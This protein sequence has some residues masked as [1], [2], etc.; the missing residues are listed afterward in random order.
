MDPRILKEIIN[1]WESEGYNW[2][3]LNDEVSPKEICEEYKIQDLDEVIEY[4]TFY[5]KV[6]I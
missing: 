4:F 2:W 3:A 5:R 6:N 1:L